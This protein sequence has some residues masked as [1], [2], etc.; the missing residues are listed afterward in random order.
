[1]KFLAHSALAH[2]I[3]LAQRY[4]CT[5]PPNIRPVGTFLTVRK[6]VGRKG[7]GGHESKRKT[8]SIIGLVRITQF[9]TG[10]RWIPHCGARCKRVF[11]VSKL[12]FSRARASP[13]TRVNLHAGHAIAGRVFRRMYIL[14]LIPLVERFAPV[15]RASS[16][17]N[18]AEN[19]CPRKYRAR[20]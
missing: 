16:H 12:H 15:R 19:V 4:I 10:C 2:M 20:R 13:S 3:L 9:V 1:M 11:A 6:E 5:L 14:S 17:A 7:G 8:Q 18:N